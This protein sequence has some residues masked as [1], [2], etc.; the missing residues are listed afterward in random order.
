MKSYIQSV[1]AKSVLGFGSALLAA[2]MLSAGSASAAT[3]VSTELVLSVD[4]SGSV[5]STEFALQRDG[6]VNAFRDA[7]LISQI[8]SLTGGIAVS[9]V[10]WATS[11]TQ[12]TSWFHIT[13]AASS[14]AFAD[15]IAAVN[16]PTN[17]GGMTDIADG[18]DLSTN[19]LLNNDFDGKRLVIDVSG[20][21]RQNTGCN[22]DCV[23]RVQAS[24]DA[25]VN[26]GIIINGLPILTDVSD[27]DD[28]YT[29]NV[30][31]G[32]NSFVRPANGFDD[33]EQAVKDKV[34]REIKADVPEPTM[35]LGLAVVGVLGLGSKLKKNESN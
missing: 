28:Y 7:D 14:N 8:E 27:L 33:F 30:I 24:R 35:M 12:A 5:N 16:R 26:S 13:D 4:V 15:A 21:G 17:I 19:I 25:A 31:G 32:P 9:L 6:Y 20:D 10:Y 3:M 23:G 18:I 22:G 29:A 34:G 2:G 11:A 1:P